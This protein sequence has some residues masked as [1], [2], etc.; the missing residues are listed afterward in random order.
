MTR[1]ERQGLPLTPDPAPQQSSNYKNKNSK[2]K[3]KKVNQAAVQHSHLPVLSLAF[4]LLLIGCASTSNAV[5]RETYLA[6]A[7]NA[8][9]EKK[10]ETAYRFLEDEFVSKIPEH[11]TRSKEI[12]HSQPELKSAA[13]STFTTEKIKQT[14]NLHGAETGYKIEENRISLF[15]KVSSPSEA[16]A[17]KQNLKIAIQPFQEAITKNQKIRSLRSEINERVASGEK[18]AINLYGNDVYVLRSVFNQLASQDQA[19]LLT[20]NLLLTVVP[21]D[22]VGQ[23]TTVQVINRST[24]G[25]DYG[26]RLGSALGQ[27]S[28]IDNTTWRGYSATSQLA[29]GLIGGLIGSALDDKATTRFQINYGIKAPKEEVRQVINSTND[30]SALPIGMCIW[31]KNFTQAPSALC[32]DSLPSFLK[33]LKA[34]KNGSS[35][36]KS[37]ANTSN[38]VACETGSLGTLQLSKRDCEN[39]NGTIK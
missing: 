37:K 9:S 13:I 3:D 2:N 5:Q 32:A 11:K 34:E 31:L 18:G 22:D 20:E 4:S 21:D 38:L 27:A 39:L 7:E 17:A 29:A 23:I 1:G 15:E 19:R 8:I 26:A 35:N 14:L 36:E 24:S 28:Y 30:E 16:E 12:Y 33:R 6:R 10:W 25:T